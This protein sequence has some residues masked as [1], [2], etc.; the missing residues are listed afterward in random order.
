V[1]TWSQRPSAHVERDA[2]PGKEGVG[3][4]VVDEAY[5]RLIG[6]RAWEGG[7]EVLRGEGGC[8]L[9]SLSL[10][11]YVGCRVLQLPW[12]EAGPPNHHDDKVDSDQ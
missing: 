2:A 11:L 10:S 6:R 7:F 5:L 9:L 8:S 12:R 4:Q 3:C 1:S